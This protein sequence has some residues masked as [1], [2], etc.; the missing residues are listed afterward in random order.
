MRRA[1]WGDDDRLDPERNTS[2]QME[3]PSATVSFLSLHFR[4]RIPGNA[5][6][7]Y[8][9]GTIHLLFRDVQPFSIGTGRW[10]S[11]FGSQGRGASATRIGQVARDLNFC[12]TVDSDLDVELLE[13]SPAVFSYRF[14]A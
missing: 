12:L 1:D 2:R 14:F 9:P 5:V 6:T 8:L 11:I 10:T 7:V 3:K 4:W 13:Y